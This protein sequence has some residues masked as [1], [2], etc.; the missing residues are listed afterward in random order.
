MSV[1]GVLFDK[2]DFKKI[3]MLPTCVYSVNELNAVH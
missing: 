2:A 1:I 3:L